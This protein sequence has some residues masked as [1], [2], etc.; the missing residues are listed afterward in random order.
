MNGESQQTMPPLVA[1][2]AMKK[3]SWQ[4]NNL[5]SAKN[6]KVFKILPHIFGE[7]L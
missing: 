2:Q 5:Q 1:G 6:L 7:I 4:P 3:Q